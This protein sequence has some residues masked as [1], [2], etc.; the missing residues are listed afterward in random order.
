MVQGG[1]KWRGGIRLKDVITA[2]AFPSLCA[3][4]KRTPSA[5]GR[6]A[7]GAQDSFR[8]CRGTG[9][10]SRRP[11]DNFCTRPVHNGLWLKLREVGRALT[12]AEHSAQ[13]IRVT[14]STEKRLG[15]GRHSHAGRGFLCE[16]LL[17]CH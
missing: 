5:A 2:E 16:V 3:V 11:A 14:R 7:L 6:S 1:G 13:N 12:P 8:R 10:L 9:E 15:P 17:D 4:K